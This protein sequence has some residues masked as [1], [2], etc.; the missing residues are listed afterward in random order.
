MER[1]GGF[2]R[3]TSTNDSIAQKYF[4]QGL[5][6]LYGYQYRSARRSFQR[7]TEIDKDCALAY[8]GIAYSYG[9]DINF[10]NVDDDSAKAAL[11]ALDEA[12]SASHATRGERELIAAQRLR[13]AVPAPKDRKLLD[14]R[15][16]AAMREIWLSHP[17]DPD[18]GAMF[19]EA[20][21][22]ERP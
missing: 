2:H 7:A 11:A 5:A 4:D 8:W 18:L 1:L 13:F 19:A 9:P 12:Q 15:Y 6:C 14:A 20:L 22:N 17:D 16:S 21:L 10:P 3:A